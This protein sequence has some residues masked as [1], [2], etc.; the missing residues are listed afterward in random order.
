MS[1]DAKHGTK[2][3]LRSQLWFDNPDDPDMTALYIERYMNWGITR[4]ELQSGKPIIGIAQ[5]GSDLSPCNRQH[6]V[7][8]E[9]IREGIR[10]AG[11][12]AMEF[13]VHP[14]P[15][16]GQASDRH[17][18]SQPC[19]SRPGRD[20]V[21]LPDRRRGADD[22]LRQDHAVPADGGG[23]GEHP[24]HRAFGRPDAQ[25]LV[26]G[27]AHR[28]RHDQVGSQEAQVGRQDRLEGVCRTRRLLRAVAGLLQHHGHGHD[29]EL[30]GRGARHDAAGF[31]RHSRRAQGT[32]PDGLSDG[33]AHRGDGA[34]GP[35]AVGHHDP[36]RLRERH[37]RLLGDRRLH[38]CTDPS[39][40]RRPPCRR[41]ARPRRLGAHR[42][43]H[44]A[45]GGYAARRPLP[46][47]GLSPGRR[48]AGRGGGAD[49]RRQAAASAGDHRQRQD[50]GRQLYGQ[51][52]RRPRGDPGLRPADAQ[53][54]RLPQPQGQPVRFRDHEDQRDLR[55]VPQALPVQSERSRMPSKA[56]PSSSTAARTIT[57]A[58]TIRLSASTRTR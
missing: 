46:R 35:E 42:P 3:K 29:D 52:H 58:S 31:G 57:L 37:R 45:A 9:R 14:D 23:H 30:A 53:R 39:Q 11:G 7:L 16:D 8:A 24:G 32:R 34:R 51:V 43:R 49:R 5:S 28:L 13:P 19:L 27:P 6:L 44:S 1:Y 38:Q 55:V 26:Q 25:R 20:A 10:E 36:R 47:R 54:R 22:R 50:H 18:G 33:Q 21:R 12:I 17:A 4:E 40:R 2:V 48:R 15:G 56:R 41:Q